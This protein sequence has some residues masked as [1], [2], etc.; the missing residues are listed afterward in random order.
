MMHTIFKSRLYREWFTFLDDAAI[1]TGFGHHRRATQQEAAAS[2]RTKRSS[3]Q[4]K[5]DG[6]VLSY[7]ALSLLTVCATTLYSFVRRSCPSGLGV[8]LQP[9]GPLG[10]LLPRMLLLVFLHQ[11]TSLAV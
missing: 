2:G 5:G 9:L 7:L 10:R 3:A 4:I 6:H 8:P 11:A 1:A